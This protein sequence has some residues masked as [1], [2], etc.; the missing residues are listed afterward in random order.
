MGRLVANKA[1]QTSNT[2]SPALSSVQKT[3]FKS[4]MLRLNESHLS[5]IYSNI[6]HL[7][8]YVTLGKYI[9]LNKWKRLHL[10]RLARFIDA[11]M[12]KTIEELIIVEK[13][14]WP[15][16]TDSDWK[17]VCNLINRWLLRKRLLLFLILLQCWR[18]L[19]KRIL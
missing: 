2:L 3:N 12:G 16:Y 1:S 4:M 6:W 18:I 5:L 13:S 8:R 10:T 17:N 14:Y 15:T 11:S 9:V 7:N 19:K